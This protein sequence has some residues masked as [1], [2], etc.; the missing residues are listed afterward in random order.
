MKTRHN[1]TGW[2]I[3]CP[4]CGAM[5]LMDS[6]WTLRGDPASPTFKPSIHVREPNGNVCHSWVTDGRI[7]FLNDSTHELAGQTVELPDI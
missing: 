2:I 4:G 3:E 6:R 7:Q 1:G 5:H